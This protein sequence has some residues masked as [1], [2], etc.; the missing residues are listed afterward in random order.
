MTAT[1]AAAAAAAADLVSSRRALNGSKISPLPFYLETII[2][3]TRYLSRAYTLP[4]PRHRRSCACWR[5]HRAPDMSYR[6]L[7]LTSF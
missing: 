5:I 4:K 7:E 6:I 3:E 1:A 2:K